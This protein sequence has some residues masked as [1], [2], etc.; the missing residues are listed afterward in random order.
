MAEVL[1][2]V[3][4]DILTDLPKS[5]VPRSIIVGSLA[6]LGYSESHVLNA[7]AE[8]V[9]EGKVREHTD[10]LRIMLEPEP[11]KLTER[12]A[13]NMSAEIIDSVDSKVFQVTD[14]VLAYGECDATSVLPHFTDMEEYTGQGG[15][16]PILE[17]LESGFLRVAID[18]YGDIVLKCHPVLKEHAETIQRRSLR[19]HEQNRSRLIAY[20][21]K[22][23]ELPDDSPILAA[24]HAVD[25]RKFIPA[26]LTAWGDIDRPI[27]LADRD[28]TSAAHALAMTLQPTEPKSGEKVLICGNKGGVLAALAGVMVGAKGTVLSLDAS[29]TNAEAAIKAL[30]TC[31]ELKDVVRVEVQEDLTRGREEEGPWD[32]IIV[33]GSIPKVPY[34]LFDQLDNEK[35]RILFFLSDPGGDADTAYLVK[36][37]QEVLNDSQLSRFKYSAIYGRYGWDNIAQLQKSYDHARELKTLQKNLSERIQTSAP[38][39]LARMYCEAMGIQT[40][41]PERRMNWMLQSFLVLVKYYS[42]PCMVEMDRLNV[43]DP[44]FDSDVSQI[45]I[46]SF[47]LWERILSRAAK[48]VKDTAVG[49]VVYADLFESVRHEEILEAHRRLDEIVGDGRFA[50]KKVALIAFLRHIVAYRNKS[51]HGVPRTSSEQEEMSE[52]LLKSFARILQ[53]SRLCN[54]FKLIH[55]ARS[56]FTREGTFS[57][58]GKDLTGVYPPVITWGD[59]PQIPQATV[60]LFREQNPVLRLSPWMV[61]DRGNLDQEDLFLYSK[62]KEYSTHYNHDTY[63]PKTVE[64]EFE[65][66]L[67]RHEVKP[68]T[69]SEY[70]RFLRN[71]VVDGVVD[72]REME[73]LIAAVKPLGFAESDEAAKARILQDI[74]RDYPSTYVE[75]EAR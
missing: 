11:E 70:D 52:L 28:T 19:D 36:K 5:P 9:R 57:I 25:R 63:P 42:F 2:A 62:K 56:E 61:Y 1:K 64:E 71:A 65:Q 34:D 23:L 15:P 39:P 72:S 68:G 46:D 8:I 54:G 44:V 74:K 30:K 41:T 13:P 51:V 27:P 12:S 33:N 20:L 53:V 10:G 31:D 29:P 67:A 43:S 35:G 14:C 6:T 22:R 37:N 24:L 55:V 17:A 49:K 66:Y 58:S 48:K 7:V 32:V 47:G 45:T 73:K 3:L 40:S 18:K 59:A 75:V 21:Q 69:L 16:S 38:Y 4:T 60:Y 26:A 50:R